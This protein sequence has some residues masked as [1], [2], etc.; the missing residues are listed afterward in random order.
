MA[1][2]R[3]SYEVRQAKLTAKRKAESKRRDRELW[4][5]L[6]M[7]DNIIRRTQDEDAS[8]HE[9][10]VKNL[11]DARCLVFEVLGGCVGRIR[12]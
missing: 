3:D 6:D 8:Y 9:G 2:R 10:E 11:N 7:M 12:T 5:L 1:K 4:R